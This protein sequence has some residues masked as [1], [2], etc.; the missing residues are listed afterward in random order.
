MAS[1]DSDVF[2]EAYPNASQLQDFDSYDDLLGVQLPV[3]GLIIPM[4]ELQQELHVP[5]L[6]MEA[7]PDGFMATSDPVALAQSSNIDADNVRAAESCN[8]FAPEIRDALINEQNGTLKTFSAQKGAVKNNS[9]VCDSVIDL[10]DPEKEVLVKEEEDECAFNWTS[11]PDDVISISEDEGD[12]TLV[13]QPDGSSVPIKK[14]DD[15][16]EFVWAQMGDRVIELDSDSEP[17]TASKLNLGN[18]FLRGLNPKD[19]RPPIDRSAARR[20]QEAYLRTYRRNHDLPGTSADRGL[21]KEIR[22]QRSKRSEFPVDDNGSAWMNATYTLHEDSGKTFRALKKSYYAKVK[23]DNNT[24]NDDVEFARAEKAE[25]LRLA[26][27]K[28]EY[29]DARGYSDDDI[30]EDGLFVSPSSTKTSYLKRR[31]ADSPYAEIGITDAASSKKSRPNN[32][33]KGAHQEIDQELEVNMMAGIE[34]YIAQLAKKGKGKSDGTSKAPKKSVQKRAKRKSN[35]AGYLTNPNSLLTSNVY[36]D[37]N[38]NLDREAL[39]ASGHANNKQKALAALVASVPTG[40]SKKGVAAEKNSILKSTVTLGRGIQGVCKADGLN[41]W[42]LS[43]MRSS[44]RHHQVQGAAFMKDRETGGEEPLGG[45]L[46]SLF[47][48]ITIKKQH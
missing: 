20:A 26:R 22:L 31:A 10:S 12:E 48:R 40:V 42:R 43:G 47:R 18:S 15:E 28:A 9:A 21:L 35:N 41:D 5:A 11:M 44:L 30:P 39:P 23:A 1:E 27:L 14:E 38:A 34:G 3:E 19:R 16:V 33:R 13:L 32:N 24:M 2:E 37:A 25:S 46:V 36:E 6:D 8:T 45:I 4:P 17:D 7:T 29:E